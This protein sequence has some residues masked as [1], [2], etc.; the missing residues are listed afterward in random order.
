MPTFLDVVKCVNTSMAVDVSAPNTAPDPPAND[1]PEAV[2][3]AL[4]GRV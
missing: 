2:F 4:E 1:T 3:E